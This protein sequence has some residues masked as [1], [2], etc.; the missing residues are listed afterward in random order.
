MQI[1]EIH[2]STNGG[3]STDN[4]PD[5]T[6]TPIIGHREMPASSRKNHI[7]NVR[8]LNTTIATQHM[9]HA[10]NNLI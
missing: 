4:P 3:N 9:M 10:A 5:R 6:H 8:V 2:I 7:L 1:M